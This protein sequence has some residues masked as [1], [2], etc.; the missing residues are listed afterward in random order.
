LAR[1]SYRWKEI[2][3]PDQPQVLSFDKDDVD[4]LDFVAST[5][6][7]RTIIFSIPPKSKFDIKRIPHQPVPLTSLPSVCLCVV[8][9]IDT[10]EMAGNI[11]PSIATT[12]A[13]VAALCVLQ[14]R[15]ILAGN[16]QDAKMVSISRRPDNVFISEALKPPNP[17]CQVCGIVRAELL[18]APETTLKTV[19]LT[20]YLP[21][22][23]VDGVDV[24][25]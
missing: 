2:Q 13:I 20:S 12:N 23:P 8:E 6:N 15:H 7:I 11:I 16:L 17:N 22:S 1:L 21:A 9:N 18:V 25:C 14:A 4:P 24:D 10:V 19:P 5:A 3:R